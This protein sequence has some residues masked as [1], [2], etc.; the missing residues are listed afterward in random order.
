MTARRY[1]LLFALLCPVARAQS[2]EI[3]GTPHRLGAESTYFSDK[4]AGLVLSFRPGAQELLDPLKGN[5]EYFEWE[6]LKARVGYDFGPKNFYLEDL[7]LFSVRSIF[8]VMRRDAPLSWHMRL[9]AQR[10]YDLA[11]RRCTVG[12]LELGGGMSFPTEADAATL[13]LFF[14]AEVNNSLS[15][16]DAPVRAGF[17]PSVLLHIRLSDK[18]TAQLGADYR[19][20]VPEN[21]NAHALRI[22]E[23][24]RWGFKNNWALN[25]RIRQ[26]PDLSDLAIGLMF[27]F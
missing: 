26:N 20:F 19:Y 9:G 22:R 23:E 2:E 21:I 1:L 10:L 6:Y 25:V 14:Q 13:G 8:P 4:G 15:F 7:T 17:G 16:R 12:V 18:L 3:A 24:V 5:T 27:Y 11:C